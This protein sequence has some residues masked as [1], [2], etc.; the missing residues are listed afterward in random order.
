MHRTFP[1]GVK[2]RPKSAGTTAAEKRWL[3]AIV[4]Y[5]CIACRIDGHASPALPHH[6][7]R[8]KVRIGHLFTLPLCDPGHHQNNFGI[9]DENGQL[10]IARHPWKA[11]FEARYGTELELLA[12]LKV[13]LGF[14][15]SASYEEAA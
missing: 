4:N 11:R 5:G 8:G 10:L 15:D 14:F 2:A 1:K 7:L 13:E 3:E 6:I 12:R 9:Q